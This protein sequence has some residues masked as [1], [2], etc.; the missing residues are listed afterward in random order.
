MGEHPVTRAFARRHARAR[1]ARD[2]S[3][4]LFRSYNLFSSLLNSV[5]RTAA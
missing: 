2:A 4:A 5:E 3:P 1:A